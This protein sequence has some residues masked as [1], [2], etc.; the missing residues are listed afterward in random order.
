[1]RGSRRWPERARERRVEALQRRLSLGV[2]KQHL[3]KASTDSEKRG[4]RRARRRGCRQVM[5]E[6]QL[7]S[8]QRKS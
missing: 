1:M 2:M 4:G 8:F 7:V 6:Q 5:E 3:L